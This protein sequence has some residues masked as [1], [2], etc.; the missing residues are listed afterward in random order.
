MTNRTK[1]NCITITVFLLL[2]ISS[3]VLADSNPWKSVREKSFATADMNRWIIPQTYQTIELDMEQLENTLAQAPLRFSDASY[4]TPVVLSLP[5]PNGELERFQIYDAPVM[6]DDLAA[7]YPYINSYAG[8]GLDDPTASLRFDV[9]QFGFHAMVLS[10]KH[11]GVFIDPYARGNTDYYISYYKK[12]FHTKKEMDCHFKGDADMDTDISQM[13]SVQGDCMFRTYRLALACTGEY[14]QFHGGNVPD[15][16]AAYNTS[17]TR[18]NGV[19]ER[20]AGLTMVL[21]PNT[22]TLI[23]LD[24]GSDPYTNNNGGTMLGQNQ[25][26]CDNL[27]GTANYD[28]GH[29]FST[30]GGGIAQL[31]A[32]CTNNKAEGVTGAGSPV[33]DPFDIDYVAHEMGHQYGANH[34]QN[35]ACNRNGNT[36]MEPGSASTIMGYAGICNPNVQFNSDAYFHAISIQEIANN[37]VNGSGSNCPVL[38]DP[39]NNAPTVDAGN[40]TYTL[41]VSTPFRLTAIATDLDGDALTYCWE[42]MDNTPATMPPVSTNTAGPAFRSFDPV[43]EAYRYFPK[44]T[45]LVNGID[46]DWEELPSV[47]RDMNFRVTVRDNNQGVGCTEEDDLTLNFSAAAGPFL[48]LNPNTALEWFSGETQTVTWDVAG[49]DAAPV[50][51]DNVDILLSLD[52]GLTYTDTLAIG[53]ANTGSF[54]ITVPVVNSTTCRV[55]IFC[56]D[57]VFFDISDENFTITLPPAPTFVVSATPTSHEVC[58]SVDNVVYNLNYTSL[59]GFD[60][61]ASVVVNGMPT[62]ATTA[63]SQ[64]TFMPS[65]NLTLTIGNLANVASGTYDLMVLATTDSVTTEQA[66]TLNVTNGIPTVSNLMSPTDGSTNQGLQ[67]ELSWEVSNNT[68]DYIIEIATN[69]A[70]DSNSTITGSTSTSSFITSGLSPLTVYYWRVRSANICGESA[71]TDFWSFQTGGEGC[72]TFS[73]TDTPVLISEDEVVTVSSMINV[74]NNLTISD[75]DVSMEIAHTW[76]GDL[77]AVLTSSNGSSISLFD[78]PGVPASEFG[79]RRNNILVTFDDEATMTSDDFENT[80]TPMQP[81]AIQGDFQSMDALSQLNGL[82]A[83][84]DWELIVS[85]AVDE[86]GGSIDAWSLEICYIQDAASTPDF[87]KLDLIVPSGGMGTITNSNL[88]ASAPNNTPVDIRYTILTLP[89]N[90]TLNLNGGD[91]NIGT[92]FTQEDINNN[93]LNYTN[94]N[95]SATEDQF[96]FDLTTNG[97][98]WIQNEPLNIVIGGNVLLASAILTN[99]ISCFDASDAMITVNGTGSNPPLEYSLDGTTYSSN[100]IFSD[101]APGDYMFFVKD[102]NGSIVETNTITIANPDQLIG[103]VAVMNA[104]ITVTASGGTGAISYSIDGTNFQADNTFPDLMNGDYTITVMDANSCT[105]TLMETINVIVSVEA[106]TTD[107]TCS[108]SDDGSISI[109]TVNGGIPPFQYSIDGTTFQTSTEFV[110]LNNGTYPI[111]VMD[112]NGFVFDAGNVTISAPSALT[113]SVTATDNNITAFGNGGTGNLS[114]SING[115]DFQTSNEFNN[116]PNGNYTVTVI[117]ENGCMDT[118]LEILIDFTSLDELDFDIVFQ[119]YPNPTSGQMTLV[120]DQSTERDLVFRIYDVIGRVVQEVTL[121][122]TS[123]YL[124]QQIDVAKLSAGSYEVVLTDGNLFGRKRFV[125]M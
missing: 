58:G 73:S 125:K 110:G 30:G 111:T 66:L 31:N 93:L 104:T 23:F 33:G 90:G 109:N 64:N 89:T 41:P 112:A 38:T 5:M 117:D 20:D 6:H 82:S 43:P 60:Q 87:S 119:L 95:L 50:S 1:L 27:I 62:G 9:T 80:C 115:V 75:I 14:A 4:G 18:V 57:N 114:Y 122:K 72:E 84:G 25:T 46:D 63:F 118:S 53:V 92:T 116:L 55:M 70:F 98:G 85:D 100:N 123:N 54:N 107:L 79:C 8:V 24:A 19:Y 3:S 32:P 15:V 99:G 71:N 94:T 42:Q 124:Q 16:M 39:G 26:T 83:L 17:M 102:A 76:V 40:P 47:A 29:V 69:P 68:I 120:L 44:L 56:S 88:M 81:F 48:V 67:T 28:I 34:T 12:D 106:T 49:T 65:A 103:S 35:N 13:E 22:D 45:D 21:V 77:S 61:I 113:V 36:A 11:S 2:F 74:P 78:R 37:I 7:K 97:G 91:V 105:I 108:D 59:L 121:E 86:D 10:G 101:L 96:R 52:G 51:C